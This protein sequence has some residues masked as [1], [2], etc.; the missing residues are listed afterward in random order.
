MADNDRK[1]IA[2]YVE[3]AVA[4]KF[5]Y[6]PGEWFRVLL[7]LDEPAADFA[8]RIDESSFLKD[9]IRVPSIYKSISREFKREDV[10]FCMAIM[11]RKALEAV[12]GHA[13]RKEIRAR[14]ATVTKVLKRIEL[15]TPTTTVFDASPAPT[16]DEPPGSTLPQAAIVA[17]IDDRLAFAHERFRFANG[18]TRFKYFWDQDDL[19]GNVLLPGNVVVPGFGFGHEMTGSDIDYLLSQCTHTGLV[20]ED[21][22]YRKA[23]QKLAGRRVGHG[24][25]VMDIACGL[26]P[27]AA[28][29]TSPYLIGVQLPKWV[30]EDTSGALLTPLVEVAIDYI[31]NRA[32]LIAADENTAPIPAVINLSYGTIAGPH[33]GTGALEAAIDQRIAGRSAPLSVVLPSGNHYLARCHAHLEM[34]HGTTS[35]KPHTHLNWRVQPDDKANSFVEVWMPLTVQ[36]GA[37]PHLAFRI[38]TPTGQHSGWLHP[39][40]Y[41]AWPSLNDVRFE[42][43]Y[44][45]LPGERRWLKLAMGPT[46]TY[47]TPTYANVPTV[48][49][50]TWR[51]DIE[52]HGA[53]VDFDAWV[54]RGDT[55]FGHPLWGRQSRF[56]DHAYQRFDRAGRPEQKDNTASHI[57]R[58]GTLNAIA[59][60]QYSTMIGGFRHS[61]GEPAE[62]TTSGPVVTRNGPD[63]SAVAEDSVVA[64]GVK[65][66]RAM[67]QYYAA[68]G[69]LTPNVAKPER[70]GSGRFDGPEPPS[71]D[72]RWKKW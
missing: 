44:Y 58:R 65:G 7:E 62:Y 17:V 20:D 16:V 42:A 49:S 21:E 6:L 59:T 57:H 55:P 3:W 37:R 63:A 2:P 27:K 4:T 66:D 67:V 69:D 64:Q 5:V 19:P 53:A 52:N 39:G 13:D 32:D 9:F 72:L 1:L 41:W 61:D 8:N 51:I 70:L 36:G 46:Q 23:G 47:D 71:A 68:N 45:N 43:S 34:P 24:T 25:H 14:L 48:P 12:V 18:K 11:S 31:L 60:G 29:A 30:T 40:D 50:G 54:Q 15:G 22:V 28:T 38:R 35:H 26:D 56:D 10:T 33:D